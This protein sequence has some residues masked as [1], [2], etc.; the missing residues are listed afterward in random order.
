MDSMNEGTETAVIVPQEVKADIATRQAWAR[1]L[2][3]HA[4]EQRTEAMEVVRAV[5]QRTKTVLES[6]DA[7][8]KAA[9][10]AHR[11]IV[12]QRDTFLTP[13]KEIEAAV[14][15]AVGKY[16]AEQERIRQEEERRLN[17]IAQEKARKEQERIDALARAQ[18]EKE[19]A[20]RKAEQ[21]SR[22]RAQEATNAEARKI[23]E[24]EAEKARKAAAAAA[25]KAQEREEQ[26]ANLPPPPVITIARVAEKAKGESS[27]TVWKAT[28]ENREEFIKAAVAAGRW[29]FVEI[30]DSAL[31]NFARR[32]QGTVKVTAVK[33]Y[34]ETQTRMRA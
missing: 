23:A 20:A 8:V 15:A 11:A 17:A 9:F 1:S 14:K 31:Q 26:A 22:Q 6:F 12:A 5:K 34:S 18:R 4:P 30:N 27:V 10:A 21:E 3:I 24:A 16:D 32:T 25:A 2:V 28:V 19:E 7:S 13:L 33:F 29:E